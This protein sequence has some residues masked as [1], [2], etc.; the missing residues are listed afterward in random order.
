MNNSFT[1]FELHYNT[2]IESEIVKAAGSIP[3]SPAGSVNS[4]I[5]P[6]VASVNF[7]LMHKFDSY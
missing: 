3:A 5:V 4:Q 6:S 7:V 2:F 1:H